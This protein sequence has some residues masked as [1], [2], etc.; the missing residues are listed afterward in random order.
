MIKIKHVGLIIN[1]YKK[2]PI[3]LANEII[4]WFEQRDIKVYIPSEESTQLDI[5][6]NISDS[7]ICSKVDCILV[8]GGDGTLLRA[9]RFSAGYNIPILGINLGRLGFLTEIEVNEIYDY[10]EKLTKGLYSLEKRSML[11]ASVKRNDEIIHES[12]AL[13]DIVINK[14]CF[15]RLITL[16]VF[17]EEEFIAEYSGDGTIISSPTGSTAYSLSAGGPLVYPKLDVNIITPICPHSLYAR[18]IVIPPNDVIRVVV[19]AVMADAKLN[20]DGQSTFQLLN[21]DEVLITKA[22][23]YTNLIKFKERSFFGIVRE[24]LKIID[25]GNNYE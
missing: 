14:G 6:I 12:F 9:A 25:G 21:D 5:P 3:A 15:A 20:A 16:S 4:E 23:Y 10:L 8:L 7:E 13:N 11:L 22:K 18:P 17:L 19:R 2:Q 1:Y 24:K